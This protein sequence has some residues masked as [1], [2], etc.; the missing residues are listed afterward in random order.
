MGLTCH[1][2]QFQFTTVHL[3]LRFKGEMCYFTPLVAL[4]VIA[5]LF[6]ATSGAEMMHF[7]MFKNLYCF[8]S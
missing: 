8:D 6:D 7:T 2:M 5:I 3:K 1:I 4:K